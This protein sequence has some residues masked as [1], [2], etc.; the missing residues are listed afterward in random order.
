MKLLILS[1]THGRIEDAVAAANRFTDLDMILHLGDCRKDA[2]AMAQKVKTPILSVNG[3]MDGDFS[4]RGYKILET[5]YG[6]IFVAHGHMEGVKNSLN[7]II[8]KA[9][10]LNCK[11][12]FFGHTH[13]PYFRELEGF[14]L[15]NPGSISC[16]GISGQKSYAVVHLSPESFEGSILYLK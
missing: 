7:T 11:A 16:P 2:K 3:N 14:Y 8:A 5:E 12:A 1:D 10:S 9:E 6:R 4:H 13:Q 15:L